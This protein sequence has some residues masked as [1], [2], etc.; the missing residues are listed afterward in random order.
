MRRADWKDF[1]SWVR[2]GEGCV[3]AVKA[4]WDGGLRQMS[5]PGGDERAKGSRVVM[6][7]FV[8]DAMVG[9]GCEVRSERVKRVVRYDEENRWSMTGTYTVGVYLGVKP[10]GADGGL[11]VRLDIGNVILKLWEASYRSTERLSGQ[12]L[13]HCYVLTCNMS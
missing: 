13:R 10:R 3:G 8:L 7:V 9:G 6:E 11:A 1:K 4:L 2:R 5:V 12:L